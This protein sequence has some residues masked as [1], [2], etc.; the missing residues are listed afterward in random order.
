MRNTALPTTG[1]F[2]AILQPLVYDHPTAICANA[3]QLTTTTLQPYPQPNDN[4][5]A[6]FV[7]VGNSMN[8]FSSVV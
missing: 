3:D 7:A 2:T 8:T 4:A 5:I 6:V 1:K